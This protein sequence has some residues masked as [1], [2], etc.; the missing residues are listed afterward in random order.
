MTESRW[1]REKGGKVCVLG[2]SSYLTC[3]CYKLTGE[4]FMQGGEKDQTETNKQTGL[5]ARNE[6][7][8][9]SFSCSP[10]AWVVH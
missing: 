9:I 6:E 3:S 1:C 7:M 4:T 8:R 2:F 5:G 10:I